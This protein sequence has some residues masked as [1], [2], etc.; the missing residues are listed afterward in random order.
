M[1]GE[2]TASAFRARLD[3]EA[4]E[5]Q[6]VAYRR[7]F[8]GDETF[9][10]VRMGTVFALAKEFIAMPV[11]EIE[12][13]LESPV[14]EARAGA[15]SIMGKAATHKK[16]TPARHEELYELYLRRHDRIDDWD[17]VD[18]AAHQVLGTWLLDRPRDPLYTLARS[19][20]WP[21]RRS[22]V[23]A[24]AAFLRR[25]QIDDTLTIVRMLVG[26][27]HDLV[28][29]GAGWMLR[30]ACDVDRDATVAFLDELAPVMPRAMLRA[31]I[32]KLDPDTR[33]RYLAM[34]PTK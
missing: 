7:Y 23:V 26:D 10:G 16:V 29:K 30:Y 2:R 19:G 6:R 33:K 5:E 17:L 24:T 21:E 12:R 13:L 4:N 18:L 3:A 31:G 9:I 1:T 8:P 11:T 28:H 27:E 25:G 15:C 20:F 32:E 22:A 34:R 14:H